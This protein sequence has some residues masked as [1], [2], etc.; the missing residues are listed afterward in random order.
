M[1]SPRRRSTLQQSFSDLP[2]ALRVQARR[3]SGELRAFLVFAATIALRCQASSVRGIHLALALAMGDDGRAR[4]AVRGI[5]ARQFVRGLR[6]VVGEFGGPRPGDPPLD[7][8]A[9]AIFA[10]DRFGWRP[11]DVDTVLDRTLAQ[12]DVARLVGEA[13]ATDKAGPEVM[14]PSEATDVVFHNDDR[15]KMEL[16]VGIM[17]GVLGL[18]ELEALRA[19]L[20]VHYT[21]SARF[22]PFDRDRATAI[23]NEIGAIAKR[24]GAPL[25]VEAEAH[26]EVAVAWGG[27][28]GRG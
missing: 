23:V 9:K 19:M 15:T 28:S 25:V 20:L 14:P 22:G 4:L 5:D 7:V 2:E 26:V 6:A 17:R 12:P 8:A 3:V 24:E 21:G 18:D 11:L 1:P 27:E 16:V 10:A 13:R